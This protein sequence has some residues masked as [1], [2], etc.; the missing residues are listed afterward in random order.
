MESGRMTARKRR[1]VKT[2]SV[3]IMASA[4]GVLYIG[5]TS[6]L[7]RR[8]FDHKNKRV[9]GFSAHCLDHRFAPHKTQQRVALL[10]DPSS[11]GG[12]SPFSPAR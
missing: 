6:D 8:A 10:A 7:E 12:A 11:A 2:Y 5:A 4:S 9:P 3:Y 1:P